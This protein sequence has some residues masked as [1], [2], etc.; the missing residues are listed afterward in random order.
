MKAIRPWESL[1]PGTIYVDTETTGL[2]RDA[3]VLEVCVLDDKGEALVNARCKP[4]HATKW[5]VA[6]EIHGIAPEDVAGCP[7]L[8]ELAPAIQEHIDAASRVCIYNADY[9]MPL[10]RRAGIE[11]EGTKLHDTMLD[12]SATQKEI[13]PKH[14][15]WR[16]FT[17]SVAA[18]RSHY[19]G[20]PDHSAMGDCM[21]TRHVQAFCDVRRY[22][23]FDGDFTCNYGELIARLANMPDEFDGLITTDLVAGVIGIPGAE[24]DRDVA[25]SRHLGLARMLARLEQD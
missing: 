10:L 24:L 11:V 17:L 14:G 20:K 1:V 23:A 13:D 12:F 19:P 15:S 21:A 16:W 4:E 25:L 18:E 6:Q 9:D 22:S 7:A 3:E 8:A 5:P 2:G